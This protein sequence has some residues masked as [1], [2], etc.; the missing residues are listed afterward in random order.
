MVDSLDFVL[1]LQIRYGKYA[2]LV[3][4]AAPGGR[5]RLVK[6]QP[7]KQFLSRVT[8]IGSIFCSTSGNVQV[9]RLRA[10]ALKPHIL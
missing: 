5:S 9:I 7:R 1:L 4:P 2:T 6:I 3:K 8:V 10:L